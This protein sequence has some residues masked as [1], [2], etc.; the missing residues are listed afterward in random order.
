MFN[1]KQ[2]LTIPN[3][4]GII[5]GIIG[6][7]WLIHG[8]WR[9]MKIN[10]ISKWP[11]ANA[12]VLSSLAEPA[13]SQAGSRYI[14]PQD[15]VVSKDNNN[16]QYIPRV[17][18]Q[19]RVNGKDYIS[20]NVVYSGQSSY[21]AFDTKTILADM[22]PNSVIQ[23]YYNPSNPSEAYIYNGKTSYTSIIMGV[24]LLLLAAYIFWHYHKNP[25]YVIISDGINSPSLTEIDKGSRVVRVNTNG[26][27]T[28][29]TPLFKNR[30]Y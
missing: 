11:K 16:A 30:L 22:S 25:K 29:V 18:Y 9:N 3:I 14:S 27:T 19:Y 1:Y 20:S 5:L 28:T 6:L 8:L 10:N 7:I 13:N 2:Y 26:K 15:I 12:T 24:I 21:N 17:T 4:I 23:I